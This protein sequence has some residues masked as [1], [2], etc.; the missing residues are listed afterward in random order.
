MNSTFIRKAAAIAATAT[1]AV[2]ASAM[3][4]PAGAAPLD[5]PTSFIVA[6]GG[7]GTA[8]A[9]AA[10]EAAGGTVVQEWPQIGV[11]IAM[12]SDDSFDDQ[13]RRSPGIVAA[14]SSALL[15]FTVM[16]SPLVSVSSIRSEDHPPDEDLGG[17]RVSTPNCFE[18]S[19]FSRFQSKCIAS[20]P[21]ILPSGSPPSA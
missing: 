19:L 17:T 4:A 1:C 13:A 5:A 7:T 8:K 9:V 12:A 6:Q 2:A 18:Y 15:F 21:T 14:V 10:V 3:T 20:M 16:L 11:V